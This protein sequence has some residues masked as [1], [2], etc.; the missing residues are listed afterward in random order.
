MV[1]I[2]L[3]LIASII[4]PIAAIA[5]LLVTIWKSIKLKGFYATMNTNFFNIAKQVDIFA[6][7]SFPILWNTIFRRHHGYAFGCKGET[8]SSSLGKNQLIG[9]LSLFGWVFVII[10]Y[11]LDVKYWG[12]GGHC[13]NSIDK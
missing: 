6:N 9:K 7:E 3:Y 2:L 10:L 13:L 11:I 8:L 12:K 1:G 4:F 5:N